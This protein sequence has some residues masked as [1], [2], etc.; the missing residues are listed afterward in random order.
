MI[1]VVV[2]KSN[3]M[4]ISIFLV[5]HCAQKDCLRE[6]HSLI[7]CVQRRGDKESRP[8][9]LVPRALFPSFGGGPPH[10]QSQGKARWGRACRPTQL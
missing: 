1:R 3:V 5:G 2:L 7:P 6:L 4:R 9:N 10:L 8:T